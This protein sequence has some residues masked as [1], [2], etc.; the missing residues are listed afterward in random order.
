MKKLIVLSTLI[1]ATFVSVCGQTDILIDDFENGA[2]SFAD[3]ININQPAPM[4]ATVVANP[5]SDQVN[6]SNFV[7]KWERY[8]AQSSNQPWAGFWANLNQSIVAGYHLIQVRY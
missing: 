1:L 6:S 8:D 4:T 2:I 3:E 7:W 5:V